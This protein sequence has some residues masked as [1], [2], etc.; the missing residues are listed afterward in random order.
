MKKI[1]LILIA[2]MIFTGLFSAEQKYSLNS[3][4]NKTGIPVKKLIEYL[5][6]DKHFPRN[7]PIPNL[8]NT[9]IAKLEKKFK[10]DK[11]TIITSITLSGMGVVFISL[12]VVAF[13]IAQFKHINLIRKKIGPE[14]KCRNLNNDTLIAAMFTI[15]LHELEVEEQNKMILTWRRTPISMWRAISKAETPNSSFYREKR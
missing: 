2:V 1:I 11:T 12:I 15:Y 4:K 5:N 3:L 6:L 7:E 9:Q 10:N 8:T 14:K 13:L